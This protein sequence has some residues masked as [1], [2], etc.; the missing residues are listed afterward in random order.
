M[1]NMEILMIFIAACSVSIIVIAA[2]IVSKIENM[3]ITIHN[4]NQITH[5]L[6]FG[7]VCLKDGPI[8]EIGAEPY[9]MLQP[10]ILNLPDFISKEDEVYIRS[11]VKNN[12]PII[13]DGEQGPTGKTTLVKVL[14]E[15]GAVAYEPW[16][17]AK[18]NLNK[19]IKK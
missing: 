8:S 16:E 6:M 4:L 3:Q 18:I 10:H 14:R 9:I 12:I 15:Y 17:C 2:Y 13:V 7:E 19:P 1:T 5:K 11:A